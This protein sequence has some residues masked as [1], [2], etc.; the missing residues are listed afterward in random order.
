MPLDI[1]AIPRGTSTEKDI[2]K[3]LTKEIAK[4]GGTAYKFNSEQRRAVPDRIC[5]LPKGLI[6]FV[7]CKRPGKEPTPAQRRELNRLR[8]KGQL[9]TWVSTLEEVKYLLDRVKYMIGCS[10]ILK[11]ENLRRDND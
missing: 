3:Y 11:N 10:T 6:F 7:E 5:V 4:L 9:A 8:E 2:E 1:K